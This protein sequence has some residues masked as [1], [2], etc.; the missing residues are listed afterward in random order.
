MID[1][2]PIQ[3][4]SKLQEILMKEKPE[5]AT[6]TL[7]H[8]YFV[9]FRLGDFERSI[10]YMLGSYNDRYINIYS[11]DILIEYINM[12][13]KSHGFFQLWASD[14]RVFLNTLDRVLGCK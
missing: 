4:H 1:L 13:C 14:L 6:E 12:N 10:S 7:Y 8:N 3:N 5:N 2:K 9:A 11:A